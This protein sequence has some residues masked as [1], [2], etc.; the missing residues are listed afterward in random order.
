MYDRV[1]SGIPY[2]LSD[3]KSEFYWLFELGRRLGGSLSVMGY[4][5]HV[6]LAIGFIHRIWLANQSVPCVLFFV[7]EFGACCGV[8]ACYVLRVWYLIPSIYIGSHNSSLLFFTGWGRYLSC[9]GPCDIL[10]PGCGTQRARTV[11]LII[12]RGT[13]I[14]FVVAPCKR[15]ERFSVLNNNEQIDDELLIHSSRL[16]YFSV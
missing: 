3:E 14:F 12:V 16:P 11:Y 15:E 13:F 1:Q 5:Y 7:G 6:E 9:R 10:A 8:Y 4:Y 2:W